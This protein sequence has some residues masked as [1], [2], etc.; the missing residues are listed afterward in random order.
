[1]QRPVVSNQI[2]PDAC[3]FPARAV[4][5]TDAFRSMWDTYDV[6]WLKANVER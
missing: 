2:A 6:I 4:Q 1:M 5:I 3:R